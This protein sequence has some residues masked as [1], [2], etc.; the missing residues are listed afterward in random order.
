MTSY[1]KLKFLILANE[2]HLYDHTGT[3]IIEVYPR[4]HDQEVASQIRKI[5]DRLLAN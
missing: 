2:I 5:G 4:K 1:R 3:H